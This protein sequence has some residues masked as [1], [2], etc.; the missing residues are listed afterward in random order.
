MPLTELD[1]E[2]PCLAAVI[3]CG[4]AAVLSQLLIPA[5]LLHWLLVKPW[6]S[7]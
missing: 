2:T 6:S 1:E 4:S 3:S 5:G 7:S